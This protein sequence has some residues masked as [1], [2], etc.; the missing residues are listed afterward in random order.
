MTAFYVFM[1]T[2]LYSPLKEQFTSA[3]TLCPPD[4]G[5]VYVIQK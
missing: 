4:V 5:L 2:K 1:V 3:E